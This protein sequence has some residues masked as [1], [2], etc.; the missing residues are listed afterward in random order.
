M[1]EEGLFQEW[2]RVLNSAIATWKKIKKNKNVLPEAGI[3]S[4]GRTWTG[5]CRPAYW[6][7]KELEGQPCGGRK[8]IWGGEL[9]TMRGSF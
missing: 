6:V 1:P 8:L 9:E 2:H 4:G 7:K 3:K 5:G